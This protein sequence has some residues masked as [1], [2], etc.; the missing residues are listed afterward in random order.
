MNGMTPE[1]QNILDCFSGA[2][3]GGR[4]VLLMSLYAEMQK[5]AAKGDAAAQ[6]VVAVVARMSRLI[7][8]AYTLGTPHPVRSGGVAFSKGI[9]RA[10]TAADEQSARDLVMK[11]LKKGKKTR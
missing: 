11:R 2:D 8:T 3:G 10:A 5:R 7:D 6:E 1:M 9:P 4:F